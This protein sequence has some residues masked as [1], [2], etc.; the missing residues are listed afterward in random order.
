M[1]VVL[2]GVS[3]VGKTT[4]G[5]RLAAA[6]G[7][8]FLDADAFHSPEN[9]RKMHAG[10][11]LGDADRV[12]WL[13]RLNAVLRE[14]AAAGRDVV[15]ACSALR[16]RYR[17]VLTAGVPD[18]RVVL[19]R[20]DRATLAAR[21]AA[22]PGHYMPPSLLESQLATLEEPAADEHVVAVDAGSEPGAVVDA[23]RAKLGRAKPDR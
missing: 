13:A 4:I 5:E 23:I 7:W 14:R 19:L 12:P 11:P 22:R 21:L 15:L 10:I 8:E 6:L 17:E 3:G 2:T 1:I 20:A 16:R 9:V 18:V